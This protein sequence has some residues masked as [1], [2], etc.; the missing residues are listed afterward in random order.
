MLCMRA[1]EKNWIEPTLLLNILTLHFRCWTLLTSGVLLASLHDNCRS[2]ACSWYSATL[3]HQSK[4]PLPSYFCSSPVRTDPSLHQTSLFILFCSRLSFYMVLSSS[5][6]SNK[7]D[8]IL[9]LFEVVC[10]KW[11]QNRGQVLRCLNKVGFYIPVRNGKM[12]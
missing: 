1:N 12:K 11:V 9:S 3:K 6:S 10:N 7:M 4:R 8:S 2:R 5:S